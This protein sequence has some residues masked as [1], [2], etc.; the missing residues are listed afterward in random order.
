MIQADQRRRLRQPVSLDHCISQPIPE[1]FGFAVER[2]APADHRPE[3]P[4]KLAPNMA[5]RPP[6]TQ[7]VLAGSC[8][9]AFGEL[10]ATSA[11]LEIALDL[12][13]QRLDHPRYGHQYRDSLAADGCNHFRR[14]EC[15]L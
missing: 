9:V 13:F 6:A 8:G 10:L 4:S 7:E 12:L 14:I 11:V 3:L 5:E 15:V 2:C 1:F